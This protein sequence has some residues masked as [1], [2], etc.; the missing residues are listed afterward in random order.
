MK[1]DYRHIN[2]LSDLH[3]ERV[4]L[5]AKYEEQETQLINNTKEYIDQYRPI[6]LVKS[7]FSFDA[8]DKADDKLNL[9]GKAMSLIL[10]FLLNKTIFRGSGFLTKAAIGLVSNKIGS[11]FDIDQLTG[12]FD[13]VKGWLSS[14]SRKDKSEKDYGIP[15]DSETY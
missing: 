7:L 10:P 15:P 8:L 14:K 2:S 4:K 6:N 5:K 11:K 3:L 1:R 13:K 12:L 9:S